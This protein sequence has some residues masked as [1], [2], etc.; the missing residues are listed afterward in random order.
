MDMNKVNQ[1]IQLH[2]KFTEGED[3]IKNYEEHYDEPEWRLVIKQ[4]HDEQTRIL[5][6]K[7]SSERQVCFYVRVSKDEYENGF[8][9][10]VVLDEM[11]A[12]TRAFSIEDDGVDYDKIN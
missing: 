11:K 12:G 2:R 10:D 6:E 7:I 1:Y 4:Y 8:D 3:D 5:K 9:T